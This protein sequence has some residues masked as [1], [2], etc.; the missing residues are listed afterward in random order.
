M[1][2]P[3]RFIRSVIPALDAMPRGPSP[4]NWGPSASVHAGE[5]GKKTGEGLHSRSD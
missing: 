5:L 2:Y 1:A 3:N 4:R